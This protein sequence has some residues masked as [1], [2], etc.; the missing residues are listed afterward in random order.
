MSKD[1]YNAADVVKDLVSGGIDLAPPD[2]VDARNRVCD[3]CEAQNALLHVCTA[4]G[5]FLPAKTR[6]L[7]TD[8]PLEIWPDPVPFGK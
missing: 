7:K 3:E 4:C 6:I 8:C 5:C 1:S 2:L